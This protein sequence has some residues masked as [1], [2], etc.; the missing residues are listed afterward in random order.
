MANTR[1]LWER[2]WEVEHYIITH[3]VWG[4]DG[5]IRNAERLLREIQPDW[6]EHEIEY[7]ES[8]VELLEWLESH[9]SVAKR[10]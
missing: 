5:T 2:L 8:V 6:A 3:N 7:L 9:L 1:E 10:P 4:Y